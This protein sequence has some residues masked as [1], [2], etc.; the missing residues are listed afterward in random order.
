MRDEEDAEEDDGYEAE[1]LAQH[2]KARSA[3]DVESVL[4]CTGAEDAHDDIEEE[5]DGEQWPDRVVA[6]SV[7]SMSNVLG[8]KET[9]HEYRCC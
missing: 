7:E 2:D 3:H 4:V 1:P 9:E 6:G 8:V 5:E